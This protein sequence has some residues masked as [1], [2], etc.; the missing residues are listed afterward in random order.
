MEWS[1]GRV[2][3]PAPPDSDWWDKMLFSGAVVVK[4]PNPNPN[5][6]T[7]NPNGD[8]YRM[9]YYGR[10]E[11]MWNMGVKP[12]NKSLPTGRIGM[13]LSADGTAFRRHRGSLPNGAIFD[14]SDDPAA[15]DSVHVA[16]SDAV[17]SEGKWCLYYFGGGMLELPL[18]GKPEEKHRGLRL[19]PGMASSDDG[20]LFSERFGPLLDVGKPGSWDEN[21]VSWPRV[22]SGDGKL[23]MTYHTRE[24]G[25]PAGMGFFSAGLAVSG[26]GKR[27]EKVGKILSVGELG[28][29]DEGGVSVRHVIRVGDEYVMFY[30]GSNFRF[31]FAI[32]LALSSDGVTWRKDVEC[33]REPGGPIL[34]ARTG[35]DV[36]D[37]V[38]V[39]TPYV[40][41]MPDGNFR[42]YYLGV[43][44]VEANGE[45][46]TQQGM[47]LAVS[48]GANFRLWKRYG[49]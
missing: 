14:P 40:L 36:W 43:G 22:F 44:K 30:E 31:E 33:G 37:N 41:P 17:Y 4:N 2:L 32:G 45:V 49:C 34:T 16:V 8:A 25:G 10:S 15:F 1:S 39:G 26:D 5:P 42:M 12:F 47:G 13:A 23:F 20:F 6:K 9:Y 27:W 28:S 19:L 11:D 48:D 35:E 3:G 21:G 24:S 38:I 18:V 46:T 7:S 29:W